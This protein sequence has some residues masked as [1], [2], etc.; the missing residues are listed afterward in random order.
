MTN[1]LKDREIIINRVIDAPREL[2]FDAF[3]Q[4]EHIENGG[5]R[6]GRR[7]TK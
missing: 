5:P 4:Q 7:H 3:T 1:A 2:V 6:V